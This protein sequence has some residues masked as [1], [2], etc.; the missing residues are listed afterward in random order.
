MAII[1]GQH[2]NPEKLTKAKKLRQQMTAIEKILW[3]HLRTNQP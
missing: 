2:V 1:R 3:N